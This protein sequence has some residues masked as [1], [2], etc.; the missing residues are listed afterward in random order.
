MPSSSSRGQRSGQSAS[1]RRHVLPVREHTSTPASSDRGDEFALAGIDI[2]TAQRAIFE[3]SELRF[4]FED[5]Q[6][7]GAVP[8]AL[9]DQ[10]KLYLELC[11]CTTRTFYKLVQSLWDNT[12]ARSVFLSN[13]PDTH[14]E[15]LDQLIANGRGGDKRP[16]AEMSKHNAV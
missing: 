9:E 10:V 12:Y 11:R 16:A 2:D 13:V 15:R 1:P 3:I 4:W 6:D 8:C 7:L 14:Q 5:I